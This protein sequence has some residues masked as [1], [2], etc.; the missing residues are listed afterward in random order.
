[1]YS[2]ENLGAM[3]TKKQTNKKTPKQMTDWVR[4]LHCE[5]RLE[6][7]LGVGGRLSWVG[8]TPRCVWMG[9]RGHKNP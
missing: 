2:R 6:G 7:S 8:E 9:F 5:Y 1:M 4:C 3:V